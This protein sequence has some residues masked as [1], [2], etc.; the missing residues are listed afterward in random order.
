MQFLKNRVAAYLKIVCRFTRSG[1][2]IDNCIIKTISSDAESCEEQDCGKHSFEGGMMAE[3]QAIFQLHVAKDTERK[4]K[5]KILTFLK[6]A[7]FPASFTD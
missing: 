1:G 5:P 3:L 2:H 6:K 4:R 7:A